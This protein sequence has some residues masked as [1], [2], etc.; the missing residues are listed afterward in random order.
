M[1]LNT[2]HASQQLS[3]YPPFHFSL[4]R[5]SL[6]SNRINLINKQDTRG[7]IL[8]LIKNLPKL[9]LALTTH[10]RNYT[11]GADVDKRDVEFTGNRVG[12]SSLSGSRRAMEKDSSWRLDSEVSVDLGV[13]NWHA[14]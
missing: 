4:S 6:W 3:H 1:K 11:G 5:L 10:S 13:T 7:I 2:I 14:D 12:Q 9:L 8:G